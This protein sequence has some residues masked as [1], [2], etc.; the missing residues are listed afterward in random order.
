[1]S[2][3]HFL[4]AGCLAVLFLGC[5]PSDPPQDFIKIGVAAFQHETCTFCPTPTDIEQWEHYGP[6]LQGKEVLSR[7]SYVKGFVHGIGDFSGVELVGLT[8]P[9]DPVGGSSG[10]WVTQAAF[11]KYT[12]AMV[13]D[14]RAQGDLD[15]VYLALHGA[16]AVKEIPRPEAEIVRRIREVV[17]QDVPIV[18]TLDLHGNEDAAL[19]EVADA[20]FSVKR[21]PHYDSYL[22][23]ERA[24]RMLMHIIRGTYDPVTVTRKPGVITPT[25]MQGTSVF[26]CLDIM[27]RARRWEEHHPGVVVSVMFGFPWADVPDVGATVFATTNNDP[28]LAATI[29]DDLNDYIWALRE[30]FAGLQYPKVPE[31]VQEV[32]DNVKKGL[33]PVI[34]ADYSDRMGDATFITEE[35]IAKGV[36]NF[37]IGTLA[38]APLLDSLSAAGKKAGDEVTVNIGGRLAESSGAPLRV[39]GTLEYFGAYDNPVD[40]K[41]YDRFA[42]INLGNNNRIAVSPDLYQVVYPAIFEALGIDDSTIEIIV[43]KS[44]NHFRRGFDLIDYSKSIVWIDPPLPFFGT[45]HLDALE[46]EQIP[47]TLYP[48]VRR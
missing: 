39:K 1:M 23:G 10:S 9:R 4:F 18:V 26:P 7:D 35:L 43:L 2:A 14:I 32:M 13:E 30:P 34:V 28:A 3:Q 16:M 12:N 15:G 27:E 46:Y 20:I 41:K 33:T 6:P 42:V 48:F 38:D 8:S 22:Q 45:I 44:R 29:A 36:S 47:D 25:V 5:S 11:D 24:A 19:A 17:G 21:F 31:G 37:F 40:G